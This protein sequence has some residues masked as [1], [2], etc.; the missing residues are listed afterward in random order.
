MGLVLSAAALQCEFVC[1]EGVCE[2]VCCDNCHLDMCSNWI[3]TSNSWSPCMNQF[4]LA[5]T[6][7]RTLFYYVNYFSFDVIFQQLLVVLK[8]LP[9]LNADCYTLFNS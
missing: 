3:L 4:L 8:V 9:Y 6:E 1:C 5:E 2:E 7:I